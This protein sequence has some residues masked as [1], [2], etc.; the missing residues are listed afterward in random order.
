MALAATPDAG[1]TDFEARA[2]ATDEERRAVLASGLPNDGEGSLRTYAKRSEEAGETLRK[3][4]P[5]SPE[6]AAREAGDFAEAMSSFMSICNAPDCMEV[7][8]LIGGYTMHQPRLDQSLPLLA[9]KLDT[10]HLQDPK[11]QAELVKFAAKARTSGKSLGQLMSATE[12]T[13]L[14]ADLRTQLEALEQS[15]A[16]LR[17][18]CTPR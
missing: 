6:T 9:D 10:V 15:R 16:T 18:R 7:L 3:L 4:I 12:T 14:G 11:M 13:S 1:L 8:M 5:L 2:N 17:G